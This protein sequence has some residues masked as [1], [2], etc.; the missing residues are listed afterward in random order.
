[1]FVTSSSSPVETRGGGTIF[2]HSSCRRTTRDT[3]RKNTAK[4]A[5][6]SENTA[7]MRPCRLR[8]GKF[9]I[10]SPKTG[11]NHGK[12]TAVSAIARPPAVTVQFVLHVRNYHL[13]TRET[14]LVFSSCK[15]QKGIVSCYTTRN[16]TRQIPVP[17]DHERWENKNISGA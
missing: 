10:V 12:N 16:T 1:M 8:H 5:K 6:N 13:T 11:Q 15:I 4:T 2:Q 7:K 3:T 9:I 17:A 14:R